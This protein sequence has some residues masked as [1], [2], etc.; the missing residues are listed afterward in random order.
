M[1][2]LLIQ[3]LILAYGAMS[4]V[5]LFA[6]WPTIK[7]L[8]HKK[9]SA[10]LSSYRIWTFQYVVTLL[11]AIFILQDLLFIGITICN[12]IACIIIWLLTFK[13]K[14]NPHSHAKS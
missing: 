11:Y 2:P 10:N 14:N 7:D 9:P 5:N 4:L 13:L 8:W 12:L 1:Q 3:L 6:Y